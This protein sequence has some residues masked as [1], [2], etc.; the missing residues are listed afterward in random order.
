MKLKP[1]AFLPVSS[2]SRSTVSELHCH[3]KPCDRRGRGEERKELSTEEYLLSAC[4]KL[5]LKQQHFANAHVSLLYVRRREARAVSN[6]V[7]WRAVACCYV[8]QTQTME[9]MP[10]NSLTTLSQLSSRE[11]LTVSLCLQQ[12][13]NATCGMW[14]EWPRWESELKSIHLLTVSQP[15][16]RTGENL[17]RR[18]VWLGV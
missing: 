16:K 11:R 18:D 15:E 2:R 3:R 4:W 1:L 8:K 9:G 5:S 13:K 14:V 12:W 17:S 10:A 6:I 7:P